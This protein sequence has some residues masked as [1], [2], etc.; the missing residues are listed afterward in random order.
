MLLQ[1]PAKHLLDD[2]ESLL[3]TEAFRA[4][5]GNQVH[6]ATLLGISRNVVR[7]LLQKHGLLEPRR[8]ARP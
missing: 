5:G 6:T 7:T 1:S 2:V 8:R 4:T 3:V